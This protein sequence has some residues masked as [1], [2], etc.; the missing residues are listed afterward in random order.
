LGLA[1]IVQVSVS[2]GG[3]PKRSVGSAFVSKRGLEGDSWSRPGL[4]GGPDQAVLLIASEVLDELKRRGYPV[5]PGALGE[6]LTT[7]GVPPSEWRVGQVWQ[8]GLARIQFTKPR[9]PC[10][11]IKIYGGRIGTEL[12]DNRV[13]ARDPG[14]PVWCWGGVYGRVL[15]EGR[16]ADGDRLIL[17][18]ESA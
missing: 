4:H 12:Y 13:N 6:N 16:I 5:F 7:L 1:S 10:S 8:A 2:R 9:A 15:T 3:V 11:T 18:A 17:E 14:S